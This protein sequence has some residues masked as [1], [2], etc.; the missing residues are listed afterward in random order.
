MALRKKIIL[1]TIL[2]IVLAIVA[3]LAH[4]ASDTTLFFFPIIAIFCVVFTSIMLARWT[5]RSVRIALDELKKA[6]NMLVGGNLDYHIL[7]AS[8]DEFGAVFNA[9]DHVRIRLKEEKEK[10]KRYEEEHSEMLLG[11]CHDLRSPLTSI[12]GYALGLKD[13]VADT[14]EKRKRYCDAILTRAD[15]LEWLIRSLFL[16]GERG[17]GACVFQFEKVCLDEYIRQFLSEKKSWIDE[18]RINVDYST[19]QVGAEVCMDICQMKRVFVN[20]LENT[21]RYRNVAYSSV[22]LSVKRKNS[23]IEICFTD[24]GPGVDSRHLKHL[25][26]NFYQAGESRINLEKGRGLGLAVVKRIVEGQ[27][28]KI[29]ATSERGQGLSIVMIFPNV[30]EKIGNEKN[31]DYRRRS[32]DG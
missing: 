31:T 12:K 32:A 1:S 25:F 20:L 30:Q 15:D 18:Q 24:D 4:M 23:A 29:Y 14:E 22:K 8:R 2:T 10:Q 16:L 21:V 28:G 13:G 3:L 7:Y 27:N 26:E 11:V 6:A 19:E 17:K 9:F 5:I